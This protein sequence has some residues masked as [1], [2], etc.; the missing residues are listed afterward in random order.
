MQGVNS[1][2]SVK[3]KIVEGEKRPGGSK[4]ASG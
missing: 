4:R 3:D 2:S 1:Y